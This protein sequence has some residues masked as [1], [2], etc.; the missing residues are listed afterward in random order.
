MSIWKPAELT[1]QQLGK[2][3]LSPVEKS[4]EDYFGIFGHS[5]Q[6]FVCYLF[7]IIMEDKPRVWVVIKA[8]VISISIFC[9]MI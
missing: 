1:P 9:N 7:G 8:E 4:V 6:C 5:L 2:A 3:I